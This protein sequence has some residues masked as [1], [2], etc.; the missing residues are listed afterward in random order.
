MYKRLKI[1]KKLLLYK[2]CIFNTE[3]YEGVLVLDYWDTW[4]PWQYEMFNCDTKWVHSMEELIQKAKEIRGILQFFV[5][6]N[7]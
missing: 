2:G 3:N 1:A 5:M 6:G 7:G 4:R